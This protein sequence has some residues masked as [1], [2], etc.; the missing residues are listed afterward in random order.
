MSRLTYT[1]PT[2]LAHYVL[3]LVHEFNTGIALYKRNRVAYACAKTGTSNYDFVLKKRG[4]SVIGTYTTES[5]V[6]QIVE[7]IEDYIHE[8]AKRNAAKALR[9][10]GPEVQVR[11]GGVD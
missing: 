4:P 3:S 9:T 6:E 7:D 8:T 11:P 5:T 2:A 10:A 1:A